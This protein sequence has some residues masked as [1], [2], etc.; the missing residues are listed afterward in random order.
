MAKKKPKK[1][2]KKR[3]DAPQGTKRQPVASPVKIGKAA[4]KAPPRKRG[5]PPKAKPTGEPASKP[6]AKPVVLVGKGP[7]PKIGPYARKWVNESGEWQVA[8]TDEGKRILGEW[9][10]KWPRLTGLL[11]KVYPKI[12][13]FM[14]RWHVEEEEIEQ[15]CLCAAVRSMQSFDPA[16]AK[17][18]T[19]VTKGLRN[20]ISTLMRKVA[21]EG[22]KM[23]L[24]YIYH[25]SESSNAQGSTLHEFLVS[26]PEPPTPERDI[27]AD[28]LYVLK[29]RYHTG[30]R[31]HMMVLLWGLESGEP[32]TLKRTADHFGISKERVRQ[33]QK[34]CV[35]ECRIELF[36]VWK[37]LTN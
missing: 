23:S 3:R 25:E 15:E 9:L 34:A 5:R 2:P 4:E 19:Y 20:N 31:Y 32:L 17:F 6:T 30:R 10:V 26:L 11:Y 37:T 18:S 33:I 22:G 36:K 13:E 16:I 27:R 21:K 12:K 8:L 7:E 29:R 35:N 14:D 1:I 28:I 24:D